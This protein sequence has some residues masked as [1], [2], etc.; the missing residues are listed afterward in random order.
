MKDEFV[1]KECNSEESTFIMGKLMEY[2]LAQVALAQEK[3]FIDI[4]RKYVAGNG[5]IVAGILGKMYGWNCAEVDILWVD[6]NYRGKGIGS[7]LL[8]AVEYLVKEKGGQLIHLD[9][10]DFQAKDFYIKQGY[11]VF[12]KLE[13]C[14]KGHCRYYL[15]KRL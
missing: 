14:P 3:A 9:T 12:G 2:N 13:D 7:K 10:F 8:H 4:S 6:S 1:L 15:M 5:N 11:E